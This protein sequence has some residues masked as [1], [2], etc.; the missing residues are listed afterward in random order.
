MS[1][2]LRFTPLEQ[3]NM[4]QWT[5]YVYIIECLDRSYYTGMTWN[6]DL[7]YD[8]HLSKFGGKYTAKHGVKRL[9][10][11]E[12]HSDL[13]AARKRENQIKDWSRVKKEKLINGEWK[14]DW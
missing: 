13:E 14:Q 11:L 2:R 12:E 5:W 4:K 3:Y 7:R 10:Y 8:Q 6:A 1:S 9:A